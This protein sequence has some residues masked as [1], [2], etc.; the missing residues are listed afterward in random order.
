MFAVAESVLPATAVAVA[1]FRP[2][3]LMTSEH[4]KVF[5]VADVVLPTT[6][7]ALAG[8][9]PLGGCIEFA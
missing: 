8:F 7:V 6:A 4:I 1:G 9:R 3:N 2:R 5:A